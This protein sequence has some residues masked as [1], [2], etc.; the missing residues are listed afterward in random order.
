MLRWVILIVAV[1]ILTGAATLVV[2]ILPDSQDAPKVAVVEPEITGPQPKCEIEGSLDYDFG[3]MARHDRSSHSWVVKNTGEAPLEISLHG[4]TTCSCTVSKP[5][6][7]A[8]G[9]KQ[10]LV[11]QPGK[12]DTLDLNWHTDKDGLPE[13]YSQGGTFNTNDPRRRQFMLTV[14]GRIFPAVE[15]YPPEMLQFTQMS[16]EEPHSAKVAVYS[17][18]RPDLKLTKLSSSKPGLI[19]AE[20]RPMTVEE[21]KQLKIEKG[22]IVM[23]TVKPGMPLGIFHEELVIQT[24]HPKQ[25]EIKITVAGNAFGPISVTPER[26]RMTDVVS[27][28]GATRD[29][30]LMVRGDPGTHFEVVKKPDALEVAIAKDEKSKLKGRYRMT[31]KVPPGTA[32]GTVVGDIVLK[33]DN[34]KAS[35]VKI[36]VSIL[37]TRSGP[38]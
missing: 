33:T 16:N 30:M 37:I 24:D 3:S 38:S 10:T 15:V 11:V 35:E 32:T 8:D 6:T 14:K 27:R 13:D 23:V 18:Q 4:N 21:A 2:Q 26:L 28:K 25:P 36:P 20:P 9:K 29:M 31:V 17:K 5:G 22:Y 1:V 7:D 34:P 19:V 12:S